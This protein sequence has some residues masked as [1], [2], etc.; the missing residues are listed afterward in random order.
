M[1][2]PNLDINPYLFNYKPDLQD[3]RLV[4]L[5]DYYDTKHM[6]NDLFNF[7][8]LYD[9]KLHTK[10][11]FLFLTELK[12]DYF[13]SNNVYDTCNMQTIRENTK[14]TKLGF[15][16]PDKHMSLATE[17][18]TNKIK[19]VE[20]EPFLPYTESSVM[21]EEGVSASSQKA[22]GVIFHQKSV[23][24]QRFQSSFLQQNIEFQSKNNKDLP[25]VIK[26]LRRFINPS[27]IQN[28]KFLDNR[29]SRFNKALENKINSCKH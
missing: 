24:A 21:S 28:I 29:I 1:V 20:I 16:G 22:G 15:I 3:K 26:D 11:V 4:I 23:N 18:C 8:Q 7:K 27:T 14:P 12:R 10:M 13:R 19:Y 25:Q 5:T 9:G 6:Q 2:D 17:I